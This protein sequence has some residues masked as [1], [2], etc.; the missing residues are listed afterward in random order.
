M[1][2]EIDNNTYEIGN[3]TELPDR[4]RRNGG[5]FLLTGIAP[6]L[7]SEINKMISQ[8]KLVKIELPEGKL[9]SCLEDCVFEKHDMLQGTAQLVASWVE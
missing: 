1:K 3:I 6:N 5:R 9:F 4:D 2:I 7:H 8:A